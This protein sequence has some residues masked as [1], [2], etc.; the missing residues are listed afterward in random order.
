MKKAFLLVLA[1]SWMAGCGGGELESWGCT[2]DDECK[3]GR[4]CIDGR[5]EDASSVCTSDDDCPAGQSCFQSIC[6]VCDGDADGVF[7]PACNG[8]DCDDQH[9][10]V[11]PGADEL[12]GDQLDND[13]DGVTDPAA[14][15]DDLC[16][17]IDCPDGMACDPSTGE[18]VPIC[19]E[20]C[21]G[22]EC[23]PDGCGGSCG[24]CPTGEFCNRQGL[25]ESGCVDA[26]AAGSRSCIGNAVVTCAD[27]NG[28]GCTEWSE[29]QA[30]APEQ[31]CTDGACESCTP[32]CAGLECGSDGC[33]GSCGGCDPDEHCEAG[34]CVSGCF[35]ECEWGDS[36]C[37]D[38]YSFSECGFFDQDL[39]LEYG[40]P[41]WCD[42]DSPCDPELGRC[43]GTC[44]DECEWGMSFC[45]D[46]YSFQ[47]CADFDGDGCAELGPVQL[48]P[49]SEPCNRMTGRCEGGC[50]DECFWGESFC[51]DEQGYME[52]GDWDNDECLELGPYQSCGPDNF[53]DWE[54]GR[55]YGGCRDE[56]EIWERYCLDYWF[57]VECGNFDYDPCLEFG[58]PM[59]CPPE[60]PCDWNTGFCGGCLPLS[61]SDMGFECGWQDDGCG[62]GQYCG[63]CQP[64]EICTRN[65]QC[66]ADG[67]H[68]GAGEP[69]DWYNGCPD[70][71]NA[72]YICVETPGDWQGFCSFPCDNNADCALEFPGGCCEELAPDHKVCL[73]G[74]YCNSNWP[75]YLEDCSDTMM[76]QPDML[77]IDIEGQGR[78]ICMLTCDTSVNVCPE[79][80]NCLPVEDGAAAGICLPTGDGVFGDPCT[81]TV[82]CQAG[83]VCIR[84][85]EEHQGFCNRL[86]SEFLPCPNSF[87]CILEDGTGG[88]W[89]AA[90]CENEWECDFLGDWECVDAWGAGIGTCLPN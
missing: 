51:V 55:C 24:L 74:E 61:C 46:N 17:L 71:W 87:D 62:G 10:G 14:L 50:W 78:S 75:G 90:M 73:F 33:G 13:C 39:C 82:G 4:V 31:V 76:C 7:G 84:L 22:K 56:C 8:A 6:K 3:H 80:G 20:Q 77:C 25:C 68:D 65:G 30:C 69:C 28:D 29:P 21:Q 38:A 88:I 43:R 52:C 37:L 42:E 34:R 47:E 66:R 15:C 59:E 16:A 35:D 49:E 64:G 89:C 9:G 27:E 41:V 72:A 58:E 86:C 2:G 48:C 18:C 81:L 45:M 23:G 83:L 5:C 40:P 60:L 63:D 44:W 70:D 19:A 26:C 12:C 79:G 85:D 36:Y 1:I 53:C 32:N 54:T 57:Y 11:H 67:T